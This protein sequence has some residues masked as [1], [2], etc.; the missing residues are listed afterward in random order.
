MQPKINKH[1]LKN[2]DKKQPV[3]K[4]RS[5]DSKAKE[6]VVTLQLASVVLFLFLLWDQAILWSGFEAVNGLGG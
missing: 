5:S 6:H 3:P 2:N 4:L 1:T